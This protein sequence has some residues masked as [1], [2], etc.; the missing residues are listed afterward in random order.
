MDLGQPV[1]G[2]TGPLM[3]QGRFLDEP[4]TDNHQPGESPSKG[5]AMKMKTVTIK[6]DLA[7]LQKKADL[8]VLGLQG[9]NMDPTQ[10]P[11]EG[12]L[13]ALL[14]LADEVRGLVKHTVEAWPEVDEG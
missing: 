13:A 10:V 3:I 14:E 11:D 4:S 12:E 5:D 7:T 2:T 6:P 9:L 1:C 8:L